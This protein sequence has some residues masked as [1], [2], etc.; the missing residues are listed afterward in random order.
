MEQKYNL[1][2]AYL[3]YSAFTLWKSNRGG[4]R[5]RYY[6]NEKP[7]ETSETIFGKTI[8]THLEE[9]GEIKGIIKPEKAEFKISVT[10]DDGLQLLGYLD[11]FDPTTLAITEFK[12]GHMSKDGKVPWDSVKVKKH[13]Q[14]D[15]Y[16]LLVNE[17]YGKFNPWVTLQW[18]ETA[19]VK[20]TVLFDGHELEA[21]STELKLTGKIKTFKRRIMNREIKAIKSEI[22]KVALEITE[23]YKIWQESQ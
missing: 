4:F 3:S 18:M 1:P 9:G 13:K 22:I 8:A 14:L 19:F 15:F 6:L 7:F 10:I 11:G 21:S 20:K 17:K 16:S 2:R 5:R 12:T 23:D